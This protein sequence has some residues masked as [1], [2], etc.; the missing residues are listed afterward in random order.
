MEEE[1]LHFYVLIDNSLSMDFG[2]PTKLHYA[3]QVAAALGFHRPGQPRP[4]RHRGVQRP[5]DADRCRPCAA[6]AASGGCSTSS[7]SSSRPGRATCRR[8]CAPSASSR[9]GKGIVVVLS[10]FM[11]KGGYEEALRYLIARQMDIYAIQ[12]LSQ[13]EIEPE[14][15]RRPEAGR[16]RGRRRGRDHGQ[17]AA[18]EALQAEPGRLPGGPARLLHAPRRGVSVH[19]QPGAVRSAGADVPAP[20]RVWCV[21]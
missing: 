20:A 15:D 7:T 13:E 6:A 18:A 10:D 14:I 21:E 9:S 2:T 3:K 17:R 8:R 16:R 11:D 5:A 1:D 12:I 19:Q 4:R